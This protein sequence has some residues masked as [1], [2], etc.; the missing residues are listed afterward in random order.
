MNGVNIVFEKLS[1]THLREVLEIERLSFP[2]P[3][4]Q[5][6][7]EREINFP[8]SNFY[9]AVIDGRLAAYG[10]FW[11]V[12]DEGH[13]VSLAVHPGY[14]RQGLGKGVLSFLLEKMGALSINRVLL[15][16]RNS[17]VGARQLYESFDFAITGRRAKYY[18]GEDAVLMERVL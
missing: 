7:F 12:L 2:Q 14:R 3:W 9:V 13:I 17:N 11:Q 8:L 16:V 18:Q 4:S 15:E 5:A 6:L 10:G 1:F